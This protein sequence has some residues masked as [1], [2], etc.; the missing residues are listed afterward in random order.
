[1]LY[2][3]H[4]YKRYIKK[5]MMM[6]VVHKLIMINSKPRALLSSTDPTQGNDF[7]GWNSCGSATTIRRLYPIH[8]SSHR[9]VL[10]LFR[11]YWFDLRSALGPDVG[12]SVRSY[13]TCRQHSSRCLHGRSRPRQC[14]GRS[15]RFADQAAF[16]CIWLVGNRNRVLRSSGP[17]PFSLGR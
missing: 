12:F 16:E 14:A 2:M 8:Y 15:T 10:H 11:G 6:I 7:I 5:L 4:P 1:M 9:P 13:D 3:D 17:F